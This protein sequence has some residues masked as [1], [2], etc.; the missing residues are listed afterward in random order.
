MSHTPFV[1]TVFEGSD[2]PW[3]TLY[4][5]ACLCDT[6]EDLAALFHEARQTFPDWPAAWTSDAP[7]T[8]YDVF[9]HMHPAFAAAFS[10]PTGDRH[11]HDPVPFQTTPLFMP[12]PRVGTIELV[13][14]AERGAS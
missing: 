3:R 10:G 9:C 1:G 12:L 5:V 8:V 6:R 2:D 14:R 11:D 4:S 7:P 13:A